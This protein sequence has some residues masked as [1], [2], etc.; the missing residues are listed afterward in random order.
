MR[1]FFKESQELCFLRSVRSRV[2]IVG[3][4][5]YIGFYGIPPS[6]LSP[7]VPIRAEVGVAVLPTPPPW[8]N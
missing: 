5:R 4:E 7:E 2:T 8:S 1:F 6:V 3:N